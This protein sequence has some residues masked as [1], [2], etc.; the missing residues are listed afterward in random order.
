MVP[1]MTDWQTARGAQMTQ[2]ER[3]WLHRASREL[4][5]RKSDLVIVHIGVEYGASLHCCKAGAPEARVIGVD[6]DCSKFEGDT[7]DFEMLEGESVE[8]ARKFH[9]RIDLLFVDAD[10][11]YEGV[12]ADIAEWIGKVPSGG[13]IVFHDYNSD[14]EKFPHTGSVRKAV[15]SWHWAETTWQGIDTPDSLRAYG[16]KALLKRGRSFGTIGIGVPYYK[17]CYDFWRWW[18]WLLVGGLEPGDEFLNTG[19]VPGEVPIPIA[20]NALVAA[21]LRTDRDTFCMVED[22]H[23]GAQ[24]VIRKMREKQENWDFDIV[25][26]SYP[27]R[28][29][30]EVMM[31]FDFA[32]D[33]PVNEYGELTCVLAPLSVPESGTQE[34]GGGAL[35]L[36]L[37]RR[38]VL[39]AMQ[40]T[41]NPADTFWFDWRGRNSQDVIFYDRARRV[42]ARSGMD[43]DNDIGHIGHKVYWAEEYYRRMHISREK[44]AQE[45]KN[46]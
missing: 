2:A 18:S 10:H 29:G 46:G 20:H 4:A 17:P 32:D 33:V 12:R 45:A 7:G 22:D 13:I 44:L 28:R 24:D 16:R 23:V 11:S 31:G 19:M 14:V 6:V 43:R 39:E 1:G 26:S 40:K 8:T 34:V 37:I 36:V 9:D 3:A 35:G 38:W 30:G 25:C 21:F 27:D 5:E 41:L 15:D 42:G